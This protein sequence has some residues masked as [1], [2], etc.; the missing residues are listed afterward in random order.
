MPGG[1]AKRLRSRCA[2][3]VEVMEC[4]LLFDATLASVADADVGSSSVD[5]LVATANFG[6]DAGLRVNGS[7]SDTSETYVRFNLASVTNITAATLRLTGQRTDAGGAVPVSVF[8]VPATTWVE[9]NGTHAALDTDNTPTGEITF[10]TRPVSSGSALATSNVSANTTYTWDITSYVKTEK[11]AGRNLVSLV[12]RGGTAGA[13]QFA[14]SEAGAGQPSL[15]VGEDTTGP[16]AAIVAGDITTA[17]AA[18]HS[19]VV[20]YTDANGVSPAS[21]DVNDLTVTRSGGGTVSVQSV[22]VNAANPNAVVAT[23]TLGSPGGTWN[24]PDNG[25]YTVALAAGQVTDAFGNVATGPADTFGV[26]IDDTAPTASISAPNVTVPGGANTII[27]VTYV[28]AGGIN[29]ASIGAND[30]VVTRAG[31]GSLSVSNVSVNASNPNTVIATYT[32]AAPGGSWD[33][34]DNGAYT[35]NLAAGSV[36]DVAGNAATAPPG[37]FVVSVDNAGPAAAISA[38]NVTV[39]GGTNTTVTVTYTDAGGVNT[40]SIGAN[41]ITVSR[42][43][44]GTLNITNVSIDATNP[45]AV[46][47]TYTVDAPGPA[48][49]A[50]DN[51]TYTVSLN[52]GSVTDVTGNAASGSPTTFAVAIDS[53]GPVASI[54]APNITTAGGATTVVTVT[55]TDASGVSAASIGISDI[56]VSHPTIGSLN[57]ASVS[58]DATNPTAVVATY[59]VDAPGGAWDVADSG[60]Y[61]ISLNAGAVTDTGGNAATGAPATFSVT[62]DSQGPTA[63]ITSPNLTTPGG[64]SYSFTI[65]YTDPTAVSVASIGVGDVAVAGSVVGALSVTGVVVDPAGDGAVRTATYTV[66]APGGTWDAADNDDYTI[67]LPAGAVLDTVGNP[68]A[69]A[70]GTFRVTVPDIVAPTAVIAANN[71]TA[72]GGATHSFTVTYTD[73]VAVKGST[74]GKSDVTVTRSGGGTLEVTAFA[75]NQSGDGPTRVVTYTIAAP[76]GS[77]GS[78]DNGAYSITVQ[79]SQVRDTS[80]N[81]LADAVTGTFTVN[82]LNSA[83]PA[84]AISP[85]PPVTL[86]GGATQSITVTYTDDAG[87]NAATIDAADLIVTRPGGGTLPVTL[88]GTSPG[89]NAATVVATYSIAAPGGFWNNADNGIYAVSTVAGQ[90]G[91]INGNVTAGSVSE[92]LAV[93]V[94]VGQVVTIDPSFN[95]GEAVSTGFVAE[96]VATDPLG[97]IIVAGHQ[98][99]R[100]AGNSQF[101]LQRLNGDGSLDTFFAGAGYNIGDPVLNE[102]FYAVGVDNLGRIVAAGFQGGNAMVARFKSNGVPDRKFGSG[103]VAVIDFGGPLDVAYGLSLGADGSVI[104][105]GGTGAGDDRFAMARL[106]ARGRID[107]TFG[108]AGVKVFGAPGGVLGGVGVMPDG[109]I[110]AAGSHD[111]KLAVVRLDAFGNEDGSFGQA[112]VMT[113]NSLVGRPDLGSRDHTQGVAVQRDGKIVAAAR[114]T[115]GDF[116]VAR[117][118]PAGNLDAT[119]GTGGLAT[120]DIG[121]DDDAD[122]VAVQG[123]GE[124]VVIGTSNVGGSAK[125]AVAVLRPDGTLDQNFGIGG[126]YSLEAGVGV[127]GAGAQGGALPRALPIGSMVLRGVGGLTRDGRLVLGASDQTSVP[128]S[129]PLRRLLVTGSGSMGSFGLVGGKPRKLTF[130]D[131]DGTR[132]TLSLAGGTAEAFYDGSVIDIVATGTSAASALVIK[133]VGGD[134]RIALRDVSADG[135]LRVFNGKTTDLSGTL[136]A[137]GNLGAVTIGNIGGV[138]AA[139]ANI[140]KL[141]SFG[142]ISGSTV[143]AGAILGSDAKLGGGNDA[144]GAGAIGPIK[145]AGAIAVSTI[146]AG[147]NP[148]DGV[149]RNGNDTVA[150]GSSIGNLNIRGGVDGASLFVSAAFGAAR[151]PEKAD[152]ATDGRFLLL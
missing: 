55:Y 31:G 49:N 37:S 15:F 130:F 36:T 19:V 1:G 63:L 108:N 149:F 60:T 120:I 98:G 54:S 40:A 33:V 150:P 45:N 129:S 139:A 70:S 16:A 47:A 137:G 6:Q 114:T 101:V 39:A 25:T 35:V 26:S 144:F 127:A 80:N 29:T 9:G 110:V 4:R 18:T 97:G 13:V 93:N 44:T 107:A 75:A 68:N 103:G 138:I 57:V 89:G 10:N 115:G 84:A 117:I 100:A 135:G 50:A 73:N 105:A 62:L 78:E 106:D 94:A 30:L 22:S 111:N 56:T 99:S 142:S 23:Y 27:T 41:D 20:T 32:L 88:I 119:F 148:M 5:P 76:G 7:A 43:T 151:L 118:D 126:R 146:G 77:W 96:A 65:T 147:L 134:G 124:I 79:P 143:L 83:G 104:I 116:G 38:P 28:D 67:T 123:T 64:A 2:A 12:L 133:G 72:P 74:L 51:G 122:V 85:L 52:A 152:P 14:S 95:G 125:T 42:P 136:Y 34:A 3:P 90:V 121:G 66:A 59:T 140:G 61:T 87:V 53:N 48:W 82:T 58:V 92:N 24:A 132:T 21:I 86:A 112:G 69:A 17:G 141:N 46:V 81:A 102:G 131:T 145:V 71:V 109:R 91:D 113:F 8:A 128:T 11:A